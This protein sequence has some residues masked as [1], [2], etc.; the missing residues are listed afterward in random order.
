MGKGFAIVIG[1]AAAGLMALGA[2]ALT[3]TPAA[4]ATLWNQFDNAGGSGPIPRITN[5]ASTGPTTW[6]PTMSSSRTA[7]NGR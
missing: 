5:R 4:G 7:R 6:P 3:A 1:V 2:L